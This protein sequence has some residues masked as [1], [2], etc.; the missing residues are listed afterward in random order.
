MNNGIA[1]AII[2]LAGMFIG[3]GFARVWNQPSSIKRTIIPKGKLKYFTMGEI[4][5]SKIKKWWKYGRFKHS[6]DLPPSK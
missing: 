2:V 6:G 3:I 1:I 4:W 5:M